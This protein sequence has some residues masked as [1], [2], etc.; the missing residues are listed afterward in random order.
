MHR[1][2]QRAFIITTIAITIGVMLFGWWLGS[3]HGLTSHAT[4]F[5]AIGRLAGIVATACVLLELLVMSRAPFIEKNFEL[6]EIND[7]HRYNG[8]AMTYALITHMLFLTLGYSITSHTTLWSQFWGFTNQFED[9]LKAM[10]GSV[11]FFTI[12]V[13]SMHAV[14]KK[15]PYEVWYFMHLLVYGGVLLAFGHQVH[16]GSDVMTQKW[17]QIFW[18]GIYATVFVILGYYRFMRPIINYLRHGFVVDKVIEEADNIYSIYFTGRNL[19]SFSYEAGQYAHWRFFNK[20]LWLEA[21]PFSFSSEPGAHFLRITFKTSGDFTEILKQIKPGTRVLLDGPRGSFT[22]DRADTDKVLL[23]AGGIG[24]APFV[25]SLKHLLQEGKQVQLLYSVNNRNDLAFV[26]ELKAIRDTS[27]GYFGITPHIS[28]EQGY[29]N[30]ARLLP[31]VTGTGDSLTVYV[32]GPEPMTESLKDSILPA[33]GIEK[34]QI[35]AERF[36]F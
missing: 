5:I 18:Y 2:A 9:V 3:G 15:L 25:A 21:H 8:Y 20:E 23:I 35:V 16:S 4:K 14:R 31:F 29:V 13:F 34:R 6:E 32:C 12:A 28:S 33:L 26:S 10:I 17:M 22:P 30:E 36:K 24:V 11:V 7:F 1:T 19:E 27:N